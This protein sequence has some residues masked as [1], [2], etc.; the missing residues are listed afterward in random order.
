MNE[1]FVKRFLEKLEL[2]LSIEC[3]DY[4][5]N[6]E[7]LHNE[8]DPGKAYVTLSRNEHS[9]DLDFRYLS[10]RYNFIGD[11]YHDDIEMC[12]YEDRYEIVREYDWTVRYFWMKVSPYLFP[13]KE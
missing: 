3:D 5:I 2:F 8:Q 13:I 6:V 9:V 11:E 12:L 7:I 4:D 10:I 1:H